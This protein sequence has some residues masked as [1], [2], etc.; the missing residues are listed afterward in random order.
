MLKGKKILITGASSGIGESCAEYF[1]KKGAELILVSRN[2]EKLLEISKRLPGESHIYAYDLMDLQGIK[3]IFKFCKAE[4]I[5]LDGMVHCAGMLAECPIKSNQLNLLEAAMQIHCFSFVEL[6]KFFSSRLY[7]NEGASIVAISSVSSISCDK[8]MGPYSASKAALNA[9]V[10]TMAKEF[11]TR[12]IRVNAIL[13]AGVDTP[14]AAHKR[15]IMGV[16]D[17]NA[18]DGQP[19][20]LI[21]PEAIASL[22]CYLLS[23]EARFLTGAEIP[24][25][26]GL[27]Y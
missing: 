16:S 25:S 5:I 23:S 8:G 17:E 13:P 24:V 19:L 15:E 14:M 4:G 7:S 22:A 12:K 1:S 6:G 26:A 2:R 27:Y 11:A 9:I 10:K 20:G 21:T 3:N 18:A